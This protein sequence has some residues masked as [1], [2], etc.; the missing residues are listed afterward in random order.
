[1]SLLRKRK[2]GVVLLVA[3]LMICAVCARVAARYGRRC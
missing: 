2:Y 1:M 3:V